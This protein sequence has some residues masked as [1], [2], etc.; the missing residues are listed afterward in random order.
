[1]RQHEIV[2]LLLRG[3]VFR[4]TEYRSLEEYLIEKYRFRKVGEKEQVILE[5]RHIIPADYKRILDEGA[6]IPAMLEESEKKFSALKIYEGEYLDAKVYI[7]V[8]GEVTHR[9]DMVAEASGEEQN[10]VYTSIYQLIKL[11]SSSG[12][13]LQQ[14]IERLTIDLGLDI[15][16]KEWGF[17][18]GME[19]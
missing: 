17:H 2:T 19:A 11:V 6:K 12:Y 14:L 4:H 16:S 7:Y 18:R 1:M 13:A 15:K 5:N 10:L 9:E 3:V 8:M